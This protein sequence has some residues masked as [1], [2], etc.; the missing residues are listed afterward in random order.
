MTQM[1]ED[2]RNLF[3]VAGFSVWFSMQKKYSSLGVKNKD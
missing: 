3:A 2:F 1:Q